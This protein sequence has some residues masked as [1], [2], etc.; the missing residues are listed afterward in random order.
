M[1]KNDKLLRL[2]RKVY[3]AFLGVAA[4]VM[5]SRPASM[6][7]AGLTVG[8]TI[9]YI[10]VEILYRRAEKTISEPVLPKAIAIMRRGSNWRFAAA[11]AGA[12]LAIRFHFNLISFMIGLIVPQLIVTLIYIVQNT[13]HGKG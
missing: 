12:L 11:T 7:I 4:L 10:N 5:L 1:N 13:S 8:L 9:G 2:G 6:V 3:A